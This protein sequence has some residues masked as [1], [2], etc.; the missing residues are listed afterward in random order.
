[1]SL[2]PKDYTYREA[3]GEGFSDKAKVMGFARSPCPFVP[4][5]DPL[6]EWPKGILRDLLVWWESGGSDGLHLFGP[7]GAGKS[8]AYRQFCASLGIPLYETSLV[9]GVEFQELVTHLDLVGGNTIPAYSHLPLAMGVDGFPGLLLL[10]ELDRADPS[11]AVC[12]HDTLDGRPLTVQM[13]AGLEEVERSNW[14]RIGSTGNSALR[15]DRNA[16]NPSVKQQDLALQDRFWLVKVSYPEPDVE[17][18]VLAR[19]APQVPLQLRQGMVECANQI[20]A[21]FMADS[22]ADNAL[23]VTISTRVLVR[24]AR[25]T[26]A[27]REGE[28]N[29]ER[30]IHYALERVLY[31]GVDG[32]PEVRKALEVI[33]DGVLGADIPIAAAA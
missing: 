8:S 17:L 23:P 9:A 5:R 25:M 10:N 6:W 1:V 18:R 31:N 13:G 3:F 33:I 30:P 7:H 28:N 32:M 21:Q 4:A 20:R 2:E 26:W 27:Y 24:W 19:A 16:L 29:G 12:L 22:D 11:T 14:F 15:G